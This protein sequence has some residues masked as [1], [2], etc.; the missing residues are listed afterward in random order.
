MYTVYLE[1]GWDGKVTGVLSVL[2][3]IDI[4]I[5]LLGALHM[6]SLDLGIYRDLPSC[7]SVVIPKR[8]AYRSKIGFA[9]VGLI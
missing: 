8:F 3:H 2:L 9:V 1:F 6:R 7:Q 5:L 4:T